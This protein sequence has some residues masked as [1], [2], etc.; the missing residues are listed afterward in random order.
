MFND[1]ED[2][3]VPGILKKTIRLLNYDLFSYDWYVRTTAATFFDPVRL[4]SILTSLREQTPLSNPPILAGSFITDATL[5]RFVQGRCMIWNE[6]FTKQL[7]QQQDVLFSYSKPDDMVLSQSFSNV[8]EIS[9]PDIVL[10]MRS[11]DTTLAQEFLNLCDKCQSSNITWAAI[12]SVNNGAMEQKRVDR[13]IDLALFGHF[14]LTRVDFLK[15]EN[16]KNKDLEIVE[17]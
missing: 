8:H 12:N 7:R 10:P 3:L 5:G 11:T 15:K 4:I 17:H 13:T 14:L 2:S 16:Q 6:S 9:L 1:M